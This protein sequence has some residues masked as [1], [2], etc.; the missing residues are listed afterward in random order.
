MHLAFHS[1]DTAMPLRSASPLGELMLMRS[2][3][4][5]GEPIQFGCRKW[6]RMAHFGIESLDKIDWSEIDLVPFSRH[7]IP[8]CAE[9]VAAH[10]AYLAKY[11]FC[12]DRGISRLWRGIPLVID[13]DLYSDFDSYA[14]RLKRRWREVQKA[15]QHGFYCRPIDRNLHRFDLFE[16]DTSLRFR[17]GGPVIAAFLRRPPERGPGDI[18]P[19]APAPPRCPLHWYTDW[20]VFA[21]GN[22]RA[23]STDR[24][25]GYLFLKRVGTFVRVTS[26][27][28]HGRYLANGIVKLLFVDAM[29]WLLDRRHQSVRGIRY[30]HYGAMEH[31]RFGLVAWKRRFGFKPL[32]FS[33]PKN[34][35][36]WLIAFSAEADETILSCLIVTG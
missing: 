12:G 19:G 21:P 25:V 33:W 11:L 17:S 6:P 9:I 2:Y 15:A 22:S 18:A 30:L 26:L 24:L 20:G 34:I 16:I 29:N 4:R 13:L 10:R 32:L 7:C 35:L 28:G 23:G 14:V 5:F 31:G 8:V 1:G 36:A 3:Y 27:M